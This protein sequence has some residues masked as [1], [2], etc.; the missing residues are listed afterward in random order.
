MDVL[1]WPSW[2]YGPNGEAAIFERPEDVPT[3]WTDAPGQQS[4]EPAT[5]KPK[6]TRRRG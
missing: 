1:K 3:G 4:A 6:T 5:E 2:K